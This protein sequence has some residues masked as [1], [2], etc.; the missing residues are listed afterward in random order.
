MTMGGD[1][2]FAVQNEWVQGD[3]KENSC[4]HLNERRMSSI[5][6]TLERHLSQ[7]LDE[8]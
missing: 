6:E 3:G 2:S 7:P 8:I 4:G 1:T 5:H